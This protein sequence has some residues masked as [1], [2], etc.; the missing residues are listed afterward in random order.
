ME[1]HVVPNQAGGWSVIVPGRSSV[2]AHAERKRDATSKGRALLRH[3]GGGELVIHSKSGR[4]V[5]R[6]TVPPDA[7][8]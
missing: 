2:V 5:E 7:S 6:D 8:N 1:R 3:E 4:I